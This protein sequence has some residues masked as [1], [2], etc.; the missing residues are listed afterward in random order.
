MT[1]VLK[2]MKRHFNVGGW[3][4][5]AALISWTDL[6]QAARLAFVAGNDA[7]RNISV[8]KNAVYDAQS[9]AAA[10]EDAGYA[11]TVSVNADLKT[12]KDELRRFR[13]R[14]KGGDEVVIFFSGHGVNMDGQNYLLPVDVR[15]ETPDELRDDSISLSQVLADL[16]TLRPAFTLVITD[17]CRNNPFEGKTRNLGGRG[18]A[19]PAGAAGEMILY[20]AGEGQT[21]L[22]R[23]GPNDSTRNGVFTRV[24]LQEM[25]RPGLPVDQVMRNVRSEV[26]RLAKGVNHEQVP[27]I[28][29]QVIGQFF[30]FPSTGG[31]VTATT[32][33]EQIRP[34]NPGTNIPS[35][36]AAMPSV[37]SNASRPPGSA[38]S[39]SLA[40]E[41]REWETARNARSAV[42]LDLFIAKYPSGRFTDTAKIMRR[43]FNQ[44]PSMQRADSG[45]SPFK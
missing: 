42:A 8:L 30:F 21:A 26:Y 22:D 17:A 36:P 37:G 24:L 33:V 20:S 15:G 29:D 38:P 39:V 25:K 13:Q 41:A 5:V 4:L 27:A 9:M 45:P 6:S 10:L 16:R 2:K 3:I 40:A 14:V 1:T 7:Y 12:F 31:S 44:A 32:V 23:L 28:Y 34:S 11:T 43:K 19:A 18:L 35:S